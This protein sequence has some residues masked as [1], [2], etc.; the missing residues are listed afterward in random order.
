MKEAEPF[1]LTISISFIRLT[2]Y[3]NEID[4]YRLT[5]QC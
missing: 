4:V 3:E 1:Y 5:R 2:Q